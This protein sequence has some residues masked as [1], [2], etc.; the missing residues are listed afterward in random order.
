MIHINHKNTLTSNLGKKHG[1]EQDQLKT[2]LAKHQSGVRTL[3][4]N[5][6]K[7]GYGFLNL[8]DDQTLVKKIKR[9]VSTQKKEK[10]ENIV[11][12]GIGG[13]ALG[14][15]AIQEAL[16]NPYAQSPK[17]HAIDNI[18]PVRVSQLMSHL[19]LARTLFIVISK[20]GG[21]VEPMALYGVARTALEKKFPKAWQKHFIFITDPKIGLLQNLAKK[22]KI[23]TFPIPSKVGG[24]FSVLSSAGLVPAA[25][26]G[27]DIDALLDGAKKM[28]EEIRKKK[29]EANPALLLATL[30]YL[31]DSQKGKNT[32]V[33]MPYSSLL[34]RFGDWYRQLLAESLGKN[35]KTGP[36]PIAAL[37]TT[38]QHSQVQLYMEGPNNKFL[39]FL[40]IETPKADV[41]VG[42]HL[43]KEMD[44]LNE[45]NLKA[46]M[47]AAHQG[48]SQA[49]A[50]AKRPNLTLNIPH[51]DEQYLGALFMLFEC[52]VALLGEMYQVNAFD[53]PGVEAGKVITK[54]IL[55]SQ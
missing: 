20:S 15:I 34:F 35:P 13:S 37:G 33:M 42:Q 44:F 3:F 8:P 10:W 14:L 22:E 19:K 1:V 17:L 18:D 12:L 41:K 7:D 2:F 25:L 49:L 38:D 29:E 6:N 36:T 45:K 32:T 27:V 24:R 21:T 47:H 50:D 11:V 43:P 51:L 46:I 28:R 52:Q 40:T 55:N 30:Q 26:A 4:R 23:T 39:I 9:F 48:T 5:K 53:Q 54:K 31:L 16:M